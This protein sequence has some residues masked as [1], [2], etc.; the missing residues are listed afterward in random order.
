MKTMSYTKK[1]CSICR[2]NQLVEILNLGLSPLADHFVDSPFDY[3]AHFPL[4]MQY[5]E[6]C[7]LAQL[8]EVVND[9]ILFKDDYSFFT[10]GSPSAVR[11]FQAYAESVAETF[12]ELVRNGFTVEI[13]S[14]DGTFLKALANNGA[15]KILGVEPA[16]SVQYEAVELNRVPTMHEF[17]NAKTAK[18]IMDI[19]GKADLIV[20]NNVLAHVD[21]L[22]DFAVGISQ[23]LDEDGV[24]IAEFQYF[25]ELVRRNL[26]DNV[27]HEHRY[28]LS[29]S[30]LKNLFERFGLRIFRCEDVDTQGGS[31]RVFIARNRQ[32]EESVTEKIEFVE[33]IIGQAVDMMQERADNVRK[34]LRD[35]LISLKADGKKVYAYGASAKGSTLLN[36]CQIDSK[37][38]PIIVDKTP[39]KY[40]KYSPGMGLK[41]IE[42]GTVDDPDYYLLLVHNYA[43]AIIN[44][45]RE[46][47]NSGGQ[48]IIPIP[49]VQIISNE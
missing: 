2:N 47:T 37:L 49:G 21:D 12:P 44:R 38:V 11:H 10:S 15:Q 20:A 6:R 14:N 1:S 27:Y 48:F 31:V 41:V 19:H 9:D 13:A 34:D 22:Y 17:F 5:C 25:P 46:F 43:T 45:E 33:Q 18:T 29:L 42:Q 35:V 30:P 28:Y 8:S 23:L 39:Y 16:D 26:F 7:G 3:D 40:G 36:F 4:K 32:V 24:F